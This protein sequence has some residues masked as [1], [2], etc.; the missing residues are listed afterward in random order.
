M[1][2]QLES[3]AEKA[4]QAAEKAARRAAKARVK[5]ENAEK[6]LADENI[7]PGDI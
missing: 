6:E 4:D 7:P 2:A 1:L 3:D 5:A